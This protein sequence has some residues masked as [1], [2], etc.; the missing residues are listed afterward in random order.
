M[1]VRNYRSSTM[2]VCL[3]SHHQPYADAATG[4]SGQVEQH[5]A[6]DFLDIPQF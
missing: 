1:Y 2:L 4:A 5:R 6:G 3:K